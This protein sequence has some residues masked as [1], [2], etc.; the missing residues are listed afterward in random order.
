MNWLSH[1][2]ESKPGLR[3]RRWR[4]GSTAP[5]GFSKTFPDRVFEEYTG[6]PW[7]GQVWLN[8]ELWSTGG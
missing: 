6:M 2:L 5:S 8:N 1:K 4:V 7:G 3:Y